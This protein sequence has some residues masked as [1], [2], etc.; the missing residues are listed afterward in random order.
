VTDYSRPREVLFTVQTPYQGA[1]TVVCYRDTWEQHVAF[2]RTQTPG[3]QL[4]VMKTLQ[5]PSIV[6]EGTSNPNY[7]AFVNTV[8]TSPGSGSP[9]VVFVDPHA[10]PDPRFATFSFRRDFRNLSS[11]SVLWSPP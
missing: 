8:V 10:K 1:S 4:S 2:S 11:F 7:I 3:I 9:L 6:C 5:A